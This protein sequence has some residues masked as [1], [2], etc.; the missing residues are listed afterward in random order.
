MLAE[1]L[2]LDSGYPT[3]SVFKATFGVIEYCNPDGLCS[4]WAYQ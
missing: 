2:R 4:E 1:L 3:D